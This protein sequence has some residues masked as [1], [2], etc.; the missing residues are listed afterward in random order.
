MSDTKQNSEQPQ[1]Q[2]QDTQAPQSKDTQKEEKPTEKELTTKV[3]EA[4][5]NLSDSNVSIVVHYLNKYPKKWSSDSFKESVNKILP[6]AFAYNMRPSN[7]LLGAVIAI[8]AI[9]LVVIV[10][11]LVS[12]FI[13]R[14]NKNVIEDP[15]IVNPVFI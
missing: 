15:T 10:W 4:F 11:W 7:A 5:P 6:E 13:K 2:G 9:L 12:K 8:V 14:N 3:K 1:T